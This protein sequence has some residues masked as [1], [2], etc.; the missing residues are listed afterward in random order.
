MCL[1]LHAPSNPTETDNTNDL[2]ITPGASWHGWIWS[3]SC[4]NMLGKCSMEDAT[5][6][7]SQDDIT[8]VKWLV[9][10]Q[11]NRTWQDMTKPHAT[12]LPTCATANE[13]WCFFLQGTK[14]PRFI[15]I[16]FPLSPIFKR[17]VLIFKTKTLHIVEGQVPGSTQIETKIS[18]QC[19]CLI[20]WPS[21]ASLLL[22]WFLSSSF[23]N[24]SEQKVF[25]TLRFV[26]SVYWSILAGHHPRKSTPRPSAHPRISC[27]W[28]HAV[29][30]ST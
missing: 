3:N 6:K 25:Q 24:P 18:L 23:D 10:L 12:E 11:L 7:A 30:N 29:E 14:D 17:P 28:V 15:S 19:G 13:F 27:S 8:I 5:T 4:N 2:R 1:L 9:M 20:F 26:T 21:K 22:C 16:C